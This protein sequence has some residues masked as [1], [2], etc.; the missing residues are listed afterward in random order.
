MR[1]LFRAFVFLAPIALVIVASTA[2]FAGELC[3]TDSESVCCPLFPPCEFPFELV[4]TGFNTDAPPCTEDPQNWYFEVALSSSMHDPSVNTGAIPQHGRLYLWNIFE[5]SPSRSGSDARAAWGEFTVTVTG[6]L[7]IL[8]YEPIAAGS[9]DWS[10]ETGLLS[11]DACGGPRPL[12]IGAFRI[13]PGTVSVE[14][15]SWGRVK[16]TYR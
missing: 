1:P 14:P 16:A 5:S 12:V 10:L 6:D 13:Y 8:A 3:L 11:F 4:T 15:T 2:S 9:H 7:P